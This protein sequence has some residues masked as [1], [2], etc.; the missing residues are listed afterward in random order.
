[1]WSHFGTDGNAHLGQIYYEV[2]IESLNNVP[3]L[4]FTV[5]ADY[6]SVGSRQYIILL[7][8]FVET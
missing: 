8:P 1:M 3:F 6:C 2:A 4:I 5:E 7:L